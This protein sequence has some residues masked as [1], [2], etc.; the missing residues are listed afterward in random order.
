MFSQQE[1]SLNLLFQNLETPKRYSMENQSIQT[2]Y[3][4]TILVLGVIFGSSGGVM[5]AALRTTHKLITGKESD[6]LLNCKSIRQTTSNQHMKETSLNI[7][8]KDINVLVVDGGE[9]LNEVAKG[10]ATKDP[11]FMKYHFIEVMTC[12][13]GCVNGGG[14]PIVKGSRDKAITTRAT[15]LYNLDSHAHIR[16]SHENPDIIE[17]YKKYLGKFGGHEAH[18]LLHTHFGK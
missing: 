2:Q 11:K 8:G 18:D 5:E 16:R 4:G 3:W 10:V 13:G 17:I 9:A 7:G 14:Q 6:E 15:G 12:P 1:N